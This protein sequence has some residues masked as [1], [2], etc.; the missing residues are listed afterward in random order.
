MLQAM[1]LKDIISSH[2]LYIYIYII[3]IIIFFLQYS[4]AWNDLPKVVYQPEKALS[5]SLKKIE[6]LIGY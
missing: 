3:I 5:E 2:S 6:I 1:N 4:F